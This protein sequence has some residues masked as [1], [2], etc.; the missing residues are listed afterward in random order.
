[1]RLDPLELLTYTRPLAKVADFGLSARLCGVDWL[2]V[3]G[4]KDKLA[5]LNPVWVAPEVMSREE[6]RKPADVHPTGHDDAVG[7]G[8]SRGAP[9]SGA[10]PFVIRTMVLG[11]ER[12]VIPRTHAARRHWFESP[13]ARPSFAEVVR[14]LEAIAEQLVARMPP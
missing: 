6:Y 1:V 11:G 14:E 12:P 4:A 5:Q 9:F 3:G 8:D 7:V 10:Q 2:Q 13:R